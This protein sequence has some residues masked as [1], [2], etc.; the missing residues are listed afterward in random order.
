MFGGTIIGGTITTSGGNVLTAVNS[1]NT[2]S[3]VTLDGTLDMGSV[4][5]P[6]MNVT[7]G[8]TLNGTILLGR[9]DGSGVAHADGRGHAVV[10]GHRQYPLRR[11]GHHVPGHFQRRDAD[12]R[13]GP[14]PARPERRDH[15]HLHQSG[16]HQRRPGRTAG[17]QHCGRG[18]D[19]IGTGWINQGT[20]QVDNG[21]TLNTAGTWS[22][23]GTI[24][25]QPG[26]PLEPGRLVHHGRPGHLRRPRRARSAAPA[27]R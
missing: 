17:R 27:A 25:V 15:R 8:L 26:A 19:L 5:A 12:P 6:K 13:R 9:A 1:S 22:N 16:D 10:V 2:L 4:F 20:L 18:L 11:L 24:N 21:A 14:D 3:G 7:S 23:T